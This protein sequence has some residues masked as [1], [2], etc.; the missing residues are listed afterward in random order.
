MWR[1]YTGRVATGRWRAIASGAP[2]RDVTLLVV[3]VTRLEAGRSS[4]ARTPSRRMRAAY[5]TVR[6]LSG[7]H[8]GSTGEN[9][10]NQM[11]SRCSIPFFETLASVM[12]LGIQSG[13]SS[14]AVS[15]HAHPS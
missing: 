3:R 4:C 10:R 12:S 11:E 14:G 13:L 15:F 5:E 1:R 8:F 2:T 7:Y 9:G 6:P